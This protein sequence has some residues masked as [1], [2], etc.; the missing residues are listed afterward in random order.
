M[1]TKNLH[2]VLAQ[3]DI[4][5]ENSEANL[6]HLDDLLQPLKDTADIIVLPEMFNTGFTMDTN[7]LSEM[8]NGNSIRWMQKRSGETGSAI[9]GSLIIKEGNNIYNRFV[10]AEPDGKISY[11]D[12]RHLFSMGDED[13]YYSPGKDRVT[14][15]YKGWRIAPFIC[16]DL[17]FPVWCRNRD[18]FDLIIFVANWPAARKEVWKILLKARAIENQC[19]VAG[20]N[21]IGN[22]GMGVNYSGNSFVVD[23]KGDIIG[24]SD[25]EHET[26]IRNSISKNDLDEFREKFPVNRDADGFILVES[27]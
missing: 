5:W 7:S 12:K 19:Y 27:S 8:M 16:Y 25:I 1:G 10:F 15:E 9:C 2:I 18:D 3:T 4:I 20:A 11:Y 23:P 21:R 17:R 13:K 6:K 22:D 24:P 26:I 14:I